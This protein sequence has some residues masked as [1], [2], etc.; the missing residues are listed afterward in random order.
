MVINVLYQMNREASHHRHH[1]H[2]AKVTTAPSP[3][4]YFL[5]MENLTT[6]NTVDDVVIYTSTQTLGK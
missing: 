4:G 5:E 1:H 2:S 6:S 3:G